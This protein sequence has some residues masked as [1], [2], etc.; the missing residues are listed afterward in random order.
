VTVPPVTLVAHDVG[1]VGGGMERQLSDLIHGLL[2][3]GVPVT[4]VSRSCGVAPREGLRW[5][6]VPGP[7]RPFLVA[8]PWFLVRGSITLARHRRGVVYAVGAIIVNRVD[9]IAVH[10]SH[11]GYRAKGGV[12]RA[13]RATRVYRLHAR[14]AGGLARLAERLLFRPGRVGVF[15]AVSS[16]VGDELREHLP[17]TA[18]KVRVV[19][20]GIDTRRFHPTVRAN[21][22]R[23]RAIFVGEEWEGKGL[24]HAIEGAAAAG[25]DLLV[26]G[27]GDRE[28]YS[29]IARELGAENRTSFLG[30]LADVERAYAMADAFVLP[31]AYETFSLATYEAA[32]CGLP[33][34]ATPVGGVRDLLQPGVN[35]FFVDPNAADVARALHALD[36]PHV[37]ARM[38]AAARRAAERY[39]SEAM[40]ERHIALFRT[41]VEAAA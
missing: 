40:V 9:V 4:V 35:G 16:D 24:R 32:A 19:P 25:W 34:V 14:A 20:N 10:L 11:R 12:L 5:V 7:A 6:R 8:Y 36:D 31:S 23:P 27:E 1:P 30:S 38:G 41:F 3:R 22:G 28:R 18:A 15:A 33:L 29:R 17:D 37:R 2:A 26:V 13:K 21:T 39:D